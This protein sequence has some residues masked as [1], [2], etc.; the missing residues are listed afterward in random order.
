MQKEQVRGTKDYI[1]KEYTKRM[2]KQVG[3]RSL[4]HA[5]P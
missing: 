5:P 3:L 4:M 2:A 1:K